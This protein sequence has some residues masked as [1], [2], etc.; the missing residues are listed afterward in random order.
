MKIATWNINSINARLPNVLRWL[1]EQ[2]PDVLLMQE[3]KCTDDKFPAEDFRK[4]GYE[5]AVHGQKSWNGVAILSKRPIEKVVSGLPGD[6]N[7][8]QA[9]YIEAT[10]RGVRVASIYLPNGNPVDTE[11]YPY[12]LGWMDR[13]TAHAKELLAQEAPTVLGG[14][15]NV[16]PEDRDCFD[17]ALWAED[18]LFRLESRKK[19]RELVYLGYTDAFRAC[20]DDDHQYSFWD[21]QGGAWPQNH[22]IRIDHL[23]LSPQA[24]D[25]LEGCAIDK[26]PRG[27]E[28]ASDHTPVVVQLRI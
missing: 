20:N 23:L 7:D 14:D 10:V 16:I 28:K 2:S 27:W 17:P 1:E 21:Y 22:G 26:T 5:S 11:K 15:Y 18:A 24:A 8:E 9:R 3:L 4:A 19:L 13:L 12:K 25:G 6:K